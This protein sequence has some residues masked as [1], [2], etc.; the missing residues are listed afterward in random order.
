MLFGLLALL[1]L[2][3]LFLA[4]PLRLLGLLVCNNQIV[5]I[6]EQIW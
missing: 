4:L 6:R 1:M 5:Y 3:V 2:L